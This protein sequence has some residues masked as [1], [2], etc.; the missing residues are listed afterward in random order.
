MGDSSERLKQ[1]RMRAGFKS[2]RAAALKFGWTPSTYAS[3]ENGQTPEVPRDAAIVYA[4]A[5]RVSPSWILTGEGP[6]AAQNMVRIM[7]RI[8]T[9]AEISPDLE[10]VPEEGL[11]EVE[12]PM[13]VGPDAIAFEVV[14]MSMS[15]RYD[16]GTLIICANRDRNPEQFVGQE[17][18]V[19]TAS[20]ARYLKK[21]RAGTKKG[22]FTLESFNAEPIMNVR[23]VWVGEILAI[24]PASRRVS[25]APVFRRVAG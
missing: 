14:G 12:L 21:L 5:F 4:R 6:M 10:Q 3:H 19:R 16:P 24:I 9:G 22:V 13:P 8:G 17:V 2:A 15:P 1:A 7:G 11:D 25:S 20:G 23:L 18:A